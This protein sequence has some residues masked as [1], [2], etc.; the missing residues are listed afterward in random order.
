MTQVTMSG[1]KVVMRAGQV[2]TGEGCCCCDCQFPFPEGVTPAVSGTITFPDVAGDCPAGEYAFACNFVYMAPTIQDTYLA[3]CEIDLG[4]GL[5]VSVTVFLLCV[6]GTLY[7]YPTFYAGPCDQVSTNCTI[8]DGEAV[9]VGPSNSGEW[10]AH[11][12]VESEGVCQ[13][14]AGDAVT[15]NFPCDI[16]IAYTI[17]L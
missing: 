12:P 5:I 9:A 8:C 4:D 2:G 10:H 14:S 17:T 1:G 3:C 13:P 11:Q 6:N 16:T 7:S 15:F